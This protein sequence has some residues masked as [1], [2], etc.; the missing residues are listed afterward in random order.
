I[1]GI[2]GNDIV[3]RIGPGKKFDKVINLKTTKIMHKTVYAT[4]DHT[5][6]VWEDEIEGDWSKIVVVD[7]DYLSESHQ[8]WIE[9][10]FID[11]E[12]KPEAT[13]AT[14]DRRTSQQSSSENTSSQS[15]TFVLTHLLDN[16]LSQ[17]AYFSVGNKKVW[18]LNFRNGDKII[19]TV[20]SMNPDNPMC[21]ITAND[22]FGDICDICI[23]KTSGDKVKVEFKYDGK[24]LTYKGYLLR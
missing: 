10:K 12:S 5:V 21:G 19:Y 2:K 14:D 9:T 23:T 3:I 1:F 22:N 11:K 24:R 15:Y 8:G 20:V 16:K 17:D 13:T 18:E 7:P 6:K 4:V